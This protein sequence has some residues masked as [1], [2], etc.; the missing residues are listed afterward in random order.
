V[1]SGRVRVLD[2]ARHRSVLVR[3]G[4]SYTATRR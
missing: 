2:R 1:R 4:G 3:G